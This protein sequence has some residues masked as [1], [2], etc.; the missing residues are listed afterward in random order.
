MVRVPLTAFLQ[1]K[2]G[3]IYRPPPSV[4]HR[5]VY[6]P[7]ESGIISSLTSGFNNLVNYFG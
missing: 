2:D 6:Q 4:F 5:P 3:Q 1:R 7:Q